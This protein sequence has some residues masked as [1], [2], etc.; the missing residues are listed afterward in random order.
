MDTERASLEVKADGAYY[1]CPIW[2]RDK[3][4]VSSVQ[5]YRFV[6]RDNTGDI[7]HKNYIKALLSKYTMV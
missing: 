5:P 2:C 7:S 4:A 6:L 3:N 1:S